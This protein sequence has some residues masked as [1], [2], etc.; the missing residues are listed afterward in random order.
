MALSDLKLPLYLFALY[1]SCIAPPI[2]KPIYPE[3]L[4]NRDVNG[5]Q[6][7]VLQDSLYLSYCCCF[8]PLL[9]ALSSFFLSYAIVAWLFFL[10]M[11]TR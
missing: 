7:V 9:F 8:A 6:C 5:S 2:P 10:W 1:R 11:C 4:K 3:W